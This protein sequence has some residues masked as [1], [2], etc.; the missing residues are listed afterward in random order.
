M[1]STEKKVKNVLSTP[2]HFQKFKHNLIPPSIYSNQTTTSSNIKTP[3]DFTLKQCDTMN[4]EIGK[5]MEVQTSA[6][7]T[8]NVNKEKS[9]VSCKS[10]LQCNMKNVEN[11]THG[12]HLNSSYLTAVGTNKLNSLSKGVSRP[13]GLFL[14]SPQKTS[15]VSI[16]HHSPHLPQNN[17]KLNDQ[18]VDV[19]VDSYFSDNGTVSKKEYTKLEKMY[20]DS[21]NKLDK[22]EIKFSK[23]MKSC[24]KQNVDD[25]V[26]NEN[27]N[28][29]KLTQQLEAFKFQNEFLR[30]KLQNLEQ[31][32]FSDVK[33]VVD[34]YLSQNQY[35]TEKLT[36][37]NKI[38]DLDRK[39]FEMNKENE[40]LS[41]E[42]EGKDQKYEKAM[43]RNNQ[44]RYSYEECI[45]KLNAKI[46]ETIDENE[47]VR[48]EKEDCFGK[49]DH[50]LK[51]VVEVNQIIEMKKKCID[52]LTAKINHGINK[53]YDLSN[54]MEKERETF[55]S[56]LANIEKMLKE[57]VVSNSKLHDEITQRDYHI[58]QL[59]NDLDEIKLFTHE[60][61][62]DNDKLISFKKHLDL[63]CEE[64]V[65]L[66]S[67]CKTLQST[68]ETLNIRLNSSHEMLRMQETYTNGYVNDDKHEKM[69][70]MWRGKVYSLLVLLKLQEM[71][72]KQE[73]EEC[74]EGSSIL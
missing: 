51:T 65:Q 54:K 5:I 55:E 58:K 48:I 27:N 1:A 22:L 28:E 26:V 32:Q 29:K 19:D 12:D 30:E 11:F 38:I 41:K 53:N 7:N 23:V 15:N 6:I 2:S 21:K 60:L 36:L 40:T 44:E 74:D 59:Q 50:S 61:Q 70:Q 31:G 64:I 57:E 63:Q 39:L 46:S 4:C 71:K 72:N 24:E 8:Q 10:N 17:N 34:R 45:A 9:N 43:I 16:S 3:S 66:Q 42:I 14:Q 33:V 35:E 47:K 20:V 49:Y 56:A 37:N 62:C 13:P 67:S 68:N 52:D 69:L 18:D 25:N 73:V